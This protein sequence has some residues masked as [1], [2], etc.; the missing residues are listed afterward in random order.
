MTGETRG[1]AARIDDADLPV[2]APAVGPEQRR[3]DLLGSLAR[4]ETCEAKRPVSGICK[5][6]SGDR[7]HARPHPRNDRADAQEL[8][9]HGDANFA[10]PCVGGYH[11]KGRGLR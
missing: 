5:G 4:L 8:R 10:R 6:L 2:F 3:N 9:L 7:T 1:A 11:R